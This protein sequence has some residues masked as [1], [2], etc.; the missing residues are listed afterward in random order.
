MPFSLQNHQSSSPHGSLL[1]RICLKI[2]EMHSGLLAGQDNLDSYQKRRG[3]EEREE[4]GLRTEVSL[5]RTERQ[6]NEMS[7]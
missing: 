1:T 7:T 5:L 4:E 3:R 6:V 2:K